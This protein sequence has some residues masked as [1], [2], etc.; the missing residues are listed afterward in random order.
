M[1]NADKLHGDLG[2]LE[3]YMDALEDRG[4]RTCLK[5]ST[6]TQARSL[7]LSKAKTEYER[8]AAAANPPPTRTF[9]QQWQAGAFPELKTKHDAI[10]PGGRYY[11]SWMV[12]FCWAKPLLDALD[13]KVAGIDACHCLSDAGGVMFSLDF[14]DANRQIV[15][16]ARAGT[17]YR[18]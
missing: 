14:V 3:N 10:T 17:F 12:V 11:Y 8:A 9:E 15:P 13:P 4:H 18:Q 16:A 1:D 5:T 2:S 7:L 6:Q